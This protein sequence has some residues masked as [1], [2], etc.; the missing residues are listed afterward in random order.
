M[1]VMP[2]AAI[3]TCANGFRRFA[4]YRRMID[5][6]CEAILSPVSVASMH[7]GNKLERLVDLLA[8]ES[9]GDCVCLDRLHVAGRDPP[10]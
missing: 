10:C 7:F 9:S 1:Q 4:G 3:W 2:R 6:G 5:P 8:G